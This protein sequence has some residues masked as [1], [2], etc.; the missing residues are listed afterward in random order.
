[1]SSDSMYFFYALGSTGLLFLLTYFK[2]KVVGKE[3]GEH[4]YRFTAWLAL[5]NLMG[6]GIAYTVHHYFESYPPEMAYLALFLLIALI[7][8]GLWRR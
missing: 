3:V 7:A 1:M 5:G 8:I 2:I 4:P 6:I